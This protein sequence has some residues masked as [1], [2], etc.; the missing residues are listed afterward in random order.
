M[1]GRDDQSPTFEAI[2]DSC[3]QIANVNK[4]LNTKPAYLSAIDK[5]SLE[6]MRLLAY[7]YPNDADLGAKIREI[8]IESRR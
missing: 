7:E 1:K 5:E 4:K 2:E 3:K 6:V 8:V